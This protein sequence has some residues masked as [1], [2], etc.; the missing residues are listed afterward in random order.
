LSNLNPHRLTIDIGIQLRLWDHGGDGVPVLFLHGYLDNGRSFDAL[1]QQLSIPIRALCLD[2]RGHGESQWIGAGGSYH[3]LDHLKDLHLVMNWLD[4]NQ[5][6]PKAIVAHSMGGNIASM[7]AGIRPDAI[8]SLFLLDALLPPAEPPEEQPNRLAN[9]LHNW[10]RYKP[11]RS[12]DSINDAANR[13]MQ[14]NIGLSRE[15]ALRMVQHALKPDPNEEHR[16]CFRLDPRLRGPT[17]V[18]YPESMW[19]NLCRRIQARVHLLRSSQ[20]YVAMDETTTAR[21]DAIPQS[22]HHTVDHVGHHL[23]VEDPELIAK[24]LQEFM[25]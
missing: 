14:T 11:F 6:T 13:L 9:L 22:S 12:F 21:L 4:E 20:G 25:S 23:H 3:I 8:Q 15:G 18:R 19:L 2:W 16:L 1:V 7:L 24:A 10:G 5:M 17:P